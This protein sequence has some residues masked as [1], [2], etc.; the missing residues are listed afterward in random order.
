MI[1][2]RPKSSALCSNALVLAV[3]LILAPSAWASSILG[4]MDVYAIMGAAITAGGA[5]PAATNT[6]G[7]SEIRGGDFGLASG[8]EGGAGSHN[9]PDGAGATVTTT[10]QNRSDFTRAFNGLS[11]IA[12]TATAT[13]IDGATTYAPGV[14]DLGTSAATAA[15]ATFTLDAQ[16]ESGAAWI[17][18]ATTTFT[19]GANSSVEFINQA[20]GAAVDNYGLFFLAGTTL[21]LGANSIFAGN[22]L[23][24]TINLGKGASLNGSAMANIMNLDAN[25]INATDGGYT[26]G[27]AYAPDG[28]LT[29][30]VTPGPIPEPASAVFLISVMSMLFVL[31][32]RGRSAR[33]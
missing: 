12:A 6:V 26:S 13:T 3:G 25:N 24:G 32:K 7:V 15:G 17:F 30:D 14:Y 16:G 2:K 18:R 10:E 23:A 22:L 5:A 11:N 31:L 28:S 21:D 33:R 29:T 8:V 19:I 27:L 1:T 4:S 9:F 20:P